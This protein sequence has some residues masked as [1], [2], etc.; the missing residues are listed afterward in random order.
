MSDYKNMVDIYDQVGDEEVF[1]D[2]DVAHVVLE[3]DKVMGTNT[4][5]GLE[6]DIKNQEPGLVAIK[7]TVLADFNIDKTV[8]LCFG[9]L[10]EEGKQFI[11]MD[12]E[13]EEN[14]GVEVKADCVFPNATRVQHNMEAD[15]LLQEGATFIYR[16]SHFHG[17]EG[18]VDVKARAEIEMKKGSTYKTY[19]D[20]QEGRAGKIE[21]DYESV[22]REN[23]TLEM[24]ARMQ[25][26]KS[27]KLN[28]RET[29]DLIGSG[30]R[31]LLESKLALQ[32]E[33]AGEVLNE[34]TASAPGAKG[35]VECTEIIKDDA[36]ARAVPVVD[37]QHPEAK[38]THEAAI[39]SV[40]SSQLQ[41]LMARG[42]NE[43]EAAETI[44]QGMLNG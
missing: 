12:V 26:Q 36:T 39:G 18:G 25:G 35:H 31:A 33:A 1:S 37:V 14:A 7:M 38:V 6:V 17:D 24:V 27:D 16:E 19:F 40:D 29:A 8:H 44:I 23:A 34:L 41:T 3:R 5:D 11:D 2:S 30:A 32:D 20:L 42:L 9:V 13:I 22:L 4:V 28:I 15:I 10:P 43:E 21:F